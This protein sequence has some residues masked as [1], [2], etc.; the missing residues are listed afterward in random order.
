MLVKDIMTTGVKSV[1]PDT[2]VKDVAM[3]MCLQSISGAPVVDEENNIVGIISEKDVLQ[4]MFPDIAD[5]IGEGSTPDFQAMEREYRGTME[6]Q[7]KELM[8]GNPATVEP[9]IPCLKAASIMWLRKFRRIPV[10]ENGKL[11]G[12]VSLGDVHKAIFRSSLLDG[13][14]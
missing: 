7:V 5:V 6:K 11:V 12:I 8:T 10:A 14:K 4:H 1:Q 2:L 9:D 13:V 3:L